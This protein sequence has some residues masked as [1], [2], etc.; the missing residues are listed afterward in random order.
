MARASFPS[1][2]RGCAWLA[3]LLPLGCDSSGSEHGDARRAAYIAYDEGLTAFAARNFAAAE[4]K[5]TAA[6]DAGL[7]NPDSY[8]QAVAKRALCWAVANKF[9]EA[10]ADLDKLGPAAANEVDVLVAR[11][12]IL[13]K[14]G[15]TAESRAAL[16]KA[17]KINPAVQEFKG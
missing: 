7:L 16:A 17:K 4:P 1:C 15:K 13:K 3:L 12:F 5:F 14:Q 10:L 6:I 9:D 11:S 8:C 2:L